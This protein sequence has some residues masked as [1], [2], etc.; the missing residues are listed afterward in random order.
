M[1]DASWHYLKQTISALL[2]L[3][4]I[5]PSYACENGTALISGG[6]NYPPLTWRV[7]NGLVGANVKLAKLL[8]AEVEIDA[9]ADEGGPWKRVLLRARRGKLDLL[10]GVRKNLERE[11]YLTFIEPPITPSVQS[12]F[13]STDRTFHY[14]EWQDLSGKIGGV[15]LGT[16]F[17]K[18]FD[19]FAKEQLQ[20]EQ[21]RTMKQNFNKLNLGRID[22]LLGP[23]MTTI[24]YTRLTGFDDMIIHKTAPLM[25]INEYLAIPKNSTCHQY[26]EH[27]SKRVNEVQLDGSYD[28]LLE[29][30]FILWESKLNY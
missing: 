20:I 14:Q 3:F 19:T 5:A 29:E 26:I 25:V 24:L 11:R 28:L 4:L 8:F 27:F 23:L 30:Y 17:G 9:Q 21:A 10:L 7:G 12:V 2:W 18:I 1:Y 16:S 15:T 6:P 13:T 22:Y